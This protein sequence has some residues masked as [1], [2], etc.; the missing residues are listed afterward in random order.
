M[1]LEQLKLKTKTKNELDIVEFRNGLLKCVE[2][3]YTQ[4][5]LLYIGTTKISTGLWPV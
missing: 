4:N 5:I 1:K 3:V 2:A